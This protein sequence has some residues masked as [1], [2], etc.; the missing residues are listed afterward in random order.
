MPAIINGEASLG[1]TQWTKLI[2]DNG[3]QRGNGIVAGSDGSIYIAG[4][5]GGN[6]FVCKY[7]SNGNLQWEKDISSLYWN[8]DIEANAIAIDSDDTVYITGRDKE[9]V[10]IRKIYSKLIFK[11]RFSIC[12]MNLKF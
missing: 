11:R 8:G 10:F 4:N 3:S 9:K 2:G 1:F 5:N 6:A 12:K 7:N